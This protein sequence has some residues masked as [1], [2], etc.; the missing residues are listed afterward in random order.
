MR[1]ATDN[2]EVD[3][4]R[5]FDWYAEFEG[6]RGHRD[7]DVANSVDEVRRCKDSVGFTLAGILIMNGESKMCR[8]QGH[9]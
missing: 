5:R 6:L 8:G 4:T 9:W 2:D 3:R 1:T 7:I